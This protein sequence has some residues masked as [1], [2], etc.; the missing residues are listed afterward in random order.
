MVVTL[1]ELE[2]NVKISTETD[3]IMVS[4]KSMR[5]AE[6]MGFSKNSCYAISTA[7]SELA[8]NIYKYAGS[9]KINIKLVKMG[10]SKG[11]EIIAEDNGPGIDDLSNALKDN[12][13]TSN[14]LGLGLP[15]VKRLMDD[16]YI[17]TGLNHGTK[18][19]TRKW[20]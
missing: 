17:E 16:F 9:G 15:G 5:M 1:A 10:N 3:V 18:I 4:L 13:S 8:R 11:I 19:T 6:I 7:V 14:S 20:L 2:T 12:F